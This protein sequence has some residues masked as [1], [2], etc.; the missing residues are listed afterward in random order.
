MNDF[1]IRIRLEG[2]TCYV[3]PRGE[4][5]DNVDTSSRFTYAEAVALAEVYRLSWK[6]EASIIDVKKLTEF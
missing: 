3:H 5:I 4:R 1:A 6:A 2:D